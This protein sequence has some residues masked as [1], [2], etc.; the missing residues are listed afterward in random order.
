[1]KHTAKNI[2]AA[3]PTAE[4]CS[5]S[6]YFPANQFM[7]TERRMATSLV[8]D[9]LD[10]SLRGGLLVVRAKFILSQEATVSAKK[11]LASGRSAAVA[12]KRSPGSEAKSC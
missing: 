9:A 4:E 11:A 10:P 12:Q 2:Q 3:F 8:S 6:S 5:P 7:P 1:M